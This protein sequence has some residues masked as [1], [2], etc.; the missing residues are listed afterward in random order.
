M[1]P[2]I[3]KLLQ[4]SYNQRQTR[5][6]GTDPS[7]SGISLN[8]SPRAPLYRLYWSS[9]SE[10]PGALEMILWLVR[11]AIQWS[12]VINQPH[13]CGLWGIAGDNAINTLKRSRA[14]GQTNVRN[15]PDQ[16]VGGVVLM[17]THC[18]AF[19]FVPFIKCKSSS[20]SFF[21]K[22]TGCQVG[23]V[24][25]VSRRALLDSVEYE[26][27]PQF[28]CQ[29]ILLKTKTKQAWREEQK[30][31]DLSEQH[32]WLARVVRIQLGALS[33]VRCFPSHLKEG[34]SLRS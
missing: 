4:V 12:D 5:D 24:E 26:G 32:N 23:M 8:Y 25:C 34:L 31:S 19:W 14:K 18:L 9:W 10:F 21:R 30:V 2:S 3:M 11:V 1:F 7:Q 16:Q 17:F 15:F 33:M 29:P 20:F 28:I 13:F 6:G 22:W 27:I